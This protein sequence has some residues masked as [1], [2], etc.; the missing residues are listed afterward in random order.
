MTTL[1]ATIRTSDEKLDAI[2]QAGNIPA[3]VYGAGITET[4]HISLERESFKKAWKTAGGST[5]ITLS[6]DSKTYDVLIHDFQVDPK[7][8]TVIHADF[9]ALDKSTKVTVGVELEFIGISPAV[10]S[11]TGTLEKMHH[12]IEVSGLPKDLPKNIEVDISSLENVHDQIHVRDLKL[13]SGITA[14]TDA[15]DVIVVITGLNIENEE[16]TEIDFA[17]IA[18]EKKGKEEES[19][20]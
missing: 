9:L 10:K 20:E 7:T 6:V 2:R 16:S 4:V 3:I 1:N 14:I 13:P 15:D 17:N 18:V 19:A 11:G 8:E 12:E 5:A